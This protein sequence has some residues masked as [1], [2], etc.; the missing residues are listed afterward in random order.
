MEMQYWKQ[1][2]EFFIWFSWYSFYR[3]IKIAQCWTSYRTFAIKPSAQRRRQT[4]LYYET[5]LGLNSHLRCFYFTPALRPRWSTRSWN[6]AQWTADEG[7]IAAAGLSECC[8]SIP[9][10]VNYSATLLLQTHTYSQVILVFLYVCLYRCMCVHGCVCACVHAC[11][12]E[13]QLLMLASDPLRSPGS[14]R[15]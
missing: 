11:V 15:T 8:F 1:S 3:N 6:E 4:F 9:F 10:Y 5:L 2:P 12:S 7:K 14:A 13:G